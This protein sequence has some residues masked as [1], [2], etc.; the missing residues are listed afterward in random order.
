MPEKD[1]KRLRGALRE[2]GEGFDVD[3]PWPF[4]ESRLE[5]GKKVTNSHLVK[6]LR[7]HPNPPPRILELVAD[8]LDGKPVGRGRSQNDAFDTLAK[9]LNDPAK[10]P[11]RRY[12]KLRDD[13]HSDSE[14]MEIVRDEYP[15][16]SEE[17]LKNGIHKGRKWA[18]KIPTRN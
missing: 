1:A 4:I 12:F 18:E 17:Q 2:S 5:A 13:G 16:R 15:R 9:H 3:N 6:A 8:R 11:I 7:S 14:A 10:L